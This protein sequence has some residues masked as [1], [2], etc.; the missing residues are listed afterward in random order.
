VVG[1]DNYII[2]RD[3]FML[4]TKV[5]LVQLLSLLFFLLDI[6]SYNRTGGLK[7]RPQ[8]FFF[9]FSCKN[10]NFMKFVKYYGS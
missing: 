7:P 6:L 9:T 3:K 10:Q 2:F 1:L 4:C 8:N 5:N